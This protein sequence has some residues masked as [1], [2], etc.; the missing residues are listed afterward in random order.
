[1]NNRKIGQMPEPLLEQVA[2]LQ[3]LDWSG[4]CRAAP[5]LL[6]SMVTS[7]EEPWAAL[8]LIVH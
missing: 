6:P 1:M 3:K 5:I 7:K 4:E 8:L 2:S